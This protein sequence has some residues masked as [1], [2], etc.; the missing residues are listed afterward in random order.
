MQWK[1][2]SGRTVFLLLSPLAVPTA[3]VAGFLLLPFI[4]LFIII[5]EWIGRTIRKRFGPTN[6]WSLWYAW[7][8]VRAEKWDSITEDK[9]IWL[10]NV[11]RRYFCGKTL[12]QYLPPLTAND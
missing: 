7:Y 2:P 10:E 4:V 12:Y 8:P 11:N 9:W 1:S 3:V 6:T 5:P